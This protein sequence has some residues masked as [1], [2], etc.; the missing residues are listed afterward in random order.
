MLIAVLKSELLDDEHGQLET[1]SRNNSHQDEYEATDGV[2]VPR[3]PAGFPRARIYR[4]FGVPLV[5]F[6]EETVLP[7]PIRAVDL[8]VICEN[9]QRCG[10]GDDEYPLDGVEEEVGIHLL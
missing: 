7:L 2:G 10:L 5:C 3:L 9:G 1:D 6:R 8:N 4:V